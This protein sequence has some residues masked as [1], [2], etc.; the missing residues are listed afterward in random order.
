MIDRKSP[1]WFGRCFHLKYQR[2]WRLFQF[3]RKRD[4]FDF[5]IFTSPRIWGLNF[6]TSNLCYL[7][8]SNKLCFGIACDVESKFQACRISSH[9]VIWFC[10]SLSELYYA[11]FLYKT[12]KN[13]TALFN[14]I[15][16]KFLFFRMNPFDKIYRTI[17]VKSCGDDSFGYFRRFFAK[18]YSS[19]NN[20]YGCTMRNKYPKPSCKL[21]FLILVVG[22]QNRQSRQQGACFAPLIVAVF[23]SKFLNVV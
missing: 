18:D 20:C 4:D 5:S 10:N 3:L 19:L 11:V 12:V 9:R 21:R 13:L 23:S 2:Q 17:G 15:C 1:M 8:V 16:N 22:K 7:G 14:S 6:D